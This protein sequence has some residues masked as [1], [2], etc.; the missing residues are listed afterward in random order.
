VVS[1]MD[2]WY[3]CPRFTLLRSDGTTCSGPPGGTEGCAPCHAPELVGTTPMAGPATLTSDPPARLRALLD[4][5]AVM[6]RHL[7]M[8]D[9]IVAPSRFLADMFAQN[10]LPRERVT[11]IPYG[12][13]PGR[14][15]PQPASRPRTPFRFGFCGVLSPWKAPHLAIEAVRGSAADLTLTI[16]GNTDES[17][18]ADYIARCRSLAGDDRRITFAGPYG[19]A[20]TGRVFAGID[21]LVVPSTWYENTPFVVLEAFAAG[22]PVLASD[23]GGLAEIVQHEGNGLRF[24]AGDATALR[25]ALERLARDPALFARLVPTAPASIATTCPAFAALWRGD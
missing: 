24:A 9:A 2:F 1:L 20:D 5:P 10:G 19:E 21:A 3:L 15:T 22:V 16:H 13:A 12:L 14:V 18:F 4:R 23:L 17:M 7:A 8:A 6:L 25:T 11:V